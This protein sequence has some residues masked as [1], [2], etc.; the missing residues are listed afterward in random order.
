MYGYAAFDVRGTGTNTNA[1]CVAFDGSTADCTYLGGITA[2]GMNTAG[3]NPTGTPTTQVVQCVKAGGGA[4]GFG[5]EPAAP[6]G[7]RIRFDSTTT[8]AALRGIC[9]FIVKVS[10]TDTLSFPI[11]LPAVPVAS[12]VFYIEQP[13]VITTGMTISSTGRQTLQLAGLGSTSL[14]FLN[15]GAFRTAFTHSVTGHAISNSPNYGGFTSYLH[16]VL[17]TITCGGSLT[18]ASYSMTNSV[19]S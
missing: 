13:G 12:D 4:P 16:P 18:D 17:S 3:Y 1:G 15:F 9:A 7:F 5:A 6:F 14:I 8:T 10:G 19:L 11:A 2:P